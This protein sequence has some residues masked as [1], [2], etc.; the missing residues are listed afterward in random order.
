MHHLHKAR[1]QTQ[2]TTKHRRDGMLIQRGISPHVWD[3]VFNTP[4]EILLRWFCQAQV[5]TNFLEGVSAG[6]HHKVCVHVQ[7]WDSL[8]VETAVDRIKASSKVFP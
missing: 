4:C 5:Q 7:N 2:V 8:D 3:L 1:S 6:V